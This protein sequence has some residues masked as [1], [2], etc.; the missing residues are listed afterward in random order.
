MK[1][2]LIVLILRI[3]EN[4]TSKENP[5]TQTAIADMI[6]AKYPCDRKTVGRNIRFLQEAGYPIL[7]TSRGF[8]MERRLFSHEEI[9]FIMALIRGADTD[10][11]DKE[12]LCDRLYPIL[13][14]CY[15]ER[16]E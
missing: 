6:S 5:L 14:K 9:D 1:K 7:K 3:L 13:K 4:T 2:Q 8:Y 11:I 12:D 15:K 16:E 10:R